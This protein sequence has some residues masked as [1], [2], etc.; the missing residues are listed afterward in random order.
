M[1]LEKKERP[2]V[3][4]SYENLEQL[5]AEAFDRDDYET[6]IL[7]QAE[8]YFRDRWDDT[9][10]RFAHLVEDCQAN[11]DRLMVEAG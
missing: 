3:G 2:L 10:P 8:A 5:R 6:I 4:L 7:I 9:D 11:I 1:E